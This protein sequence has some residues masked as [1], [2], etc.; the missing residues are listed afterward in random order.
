MPEFQIN[1][2]P[3]PR[4][5]IS[6]TFI[7]E[8]TKIFTEALRIDNIADL[9]AE[10]VDKYGELA[11]NKE[12]LQQY[13]F[14]LSQLI[15]RTKDNTL[16]KSYDFFGDSTQDALALKEYIDNIPIQKK[17]VFQPQTEGVAISRDFLLSPK[18]GR[19]LLTISMRGRITYPCGQSVCI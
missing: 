1:N 5:L 11:R 7:R 14:F 4:E 18:S 10:R 16:P 19:R 15:S 9:F 13:H 3:N 2:K 12:E 6:K 8:F 17:D